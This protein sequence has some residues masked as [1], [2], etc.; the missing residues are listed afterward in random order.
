M[1]VGRSLCTRPAAPRYP[2]KPPSGTIK[3]AALL[4]LVVAEAFPEVSLTK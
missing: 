1:A 4:I 3:P 2:Y